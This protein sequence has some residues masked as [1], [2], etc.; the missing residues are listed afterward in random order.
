MVTT[1]DD[2]ANASYTILRHGKVAR[3]VQV[4]ERCNVDVDGEGFPLGIE[5]LH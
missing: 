1:H 3:T 2:A 4:S 5:V